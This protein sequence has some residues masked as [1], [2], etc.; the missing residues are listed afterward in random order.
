MENFDPA[1]T[2]GGNRK[3]IFAVIAIAALSVLAIGGYYLTK[4]SGDNVPIAIVSPAPI[5]E[6]TLDSDSDTIPDL[7]EKTI[8]TDPNKMDTDGDGFDDLAEIK[9]GYSPLIAGSAKFS[10]EEL[11]VLKDK[12][13]VADTVFF[14]KEFETKNS[15]SES[16]NNLQNQLEPESY[17]NGKLDFK[18]RQPKRWKVDESG[19][20][21]THAMFINPQVDIEN[22]N[23]FNATINITS[24]SANG[25]S[26][27][28]NITMSKKILSEI[29]ADYKSLE[30]SVANLNGNEYRII[31]GTF[32]RDNNKVR[33]IQLSF[34][35]NNKV[36]VVTAT[37]LEST[38]DKY[39]DLFKASLLT[40][41]FNN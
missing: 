1:K 3:L 25:L 24:G 10:P 18:I 27:D 21:G 29:F 38:W 26:I 9:N 13:K 33:N 16:I 22:G 32:T 23:R 36:Y 15:T 28:E 7:V 30:D 41:E 35:N 39:K 19:K 14:D 40:F 17:I 6:S 8:G 12:I 31:G 20:M 4:K 37:A 2:E 34:I 11:Q 5:V